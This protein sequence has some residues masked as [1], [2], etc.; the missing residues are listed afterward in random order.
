MAQ[1]VGSLVLRLKG[2]Q[3]REPRVGPNPFCYHHQKSTLKG[4][5]PMAQEVGSLVLHLKGS[6]SREPTGFESR[7][8]V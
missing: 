1:E 7:P 5:F 4:A 2:S 6:Q 3:S 8:F